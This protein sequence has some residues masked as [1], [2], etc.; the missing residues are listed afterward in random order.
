MTTPDYQLLRQPDPRNAQVEFDGVFEGQPVRWRA[1]I[2]ALPRDGARPYIEIDPAGAD[3]HGRVHA[4]VG[5]GVEAIDAPTIRKTI[6]MLRQ[7]KRLRRGRMEFGASV[8]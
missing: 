2:L 8:E 5:L 6:I 1:T 7:Y 3:A 4:R